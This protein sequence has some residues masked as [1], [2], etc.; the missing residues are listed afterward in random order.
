MV[1]FQLTITRIFSIYF[2]QGILLALFLYLP[3]KILKQNRKRVHVLFS[4]FYLCVA[5][6]IIFNFIYAPLTDVELVKFLNFMTNY[7]MS[8]GPIFILA[9]LILFHKGEESFNTSKQLL[10]IIPYALILF[11]V[12]FIPDGVQIGPETNWSPIWS[13]LYFLYIMTVLTLMTFIPNFYFSLKVYKKIDDDLVRKKWKIFVIGEIELYILLY[14]SYISNA[15][16]SSTI[17]LIW[18]IF[19]LILAMTGAY[20]IYYGVAKRF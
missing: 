11:F 20:A 1:L 18:S 15:F 5:A 2:A 10:L 12:Y 8:L 6:G 9:F 19:M 13:I 17:R 4:T 16:A 3:Y 14:G 7:L